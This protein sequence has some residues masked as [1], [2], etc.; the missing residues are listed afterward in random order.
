M[1]T[2]GRRARRLTIASMIAEELRVRILSG[3]I[4]AGARLQQNDVAREFDVSSTPVREA[5]AELRR[6]GLATSIEHRGV[7]VVRPTLADVLEASEVE[8]LLEGPCIAASVPLLTDEELADARRRLDEHRG[9]PTDEVRRRVELDAA[10][11]L[12]L[13]VRC[14]NTK[15]R[16]LAEAA[17]R[18]TSTYRLMLSPVGH[19]GEHFV[20]IIHEQHEAIYAACADR[21]GELAAARTVDHI[22]WGGQVSR[23]ILG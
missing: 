23:E 11:H 13:L 1:T 2:T 4:P 5:F 10:F 19:I 7:R 18:D 16:T 9:V 21:D 22:R 20:E 14:P 15:L 6:Q 12:S 17:H 8:E 3:E